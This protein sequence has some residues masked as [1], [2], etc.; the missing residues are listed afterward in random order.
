LSLVESLPPGEIQSQTAIDRLQFQLAQILPR[1]KRPI[2]GT[3]PYRNLNFPSR[4]PISAPPIKPAYKGGNKT[5][6][7]DDLKSSAEAPLSKEVAELAQ[8][9][10]WNPVSIYEWVKNNVE[11]EWY[12]GCMKG[13]ETVEIDIR[14]H[15]SS[16][17]QG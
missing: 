1:K 17:S 12:W 6:A 15:F 5:V 16:R 3:L 11:P 14:S 4:E 7:P 10:L 8:S 2:F 13:D 9:L